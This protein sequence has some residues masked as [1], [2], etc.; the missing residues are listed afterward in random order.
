MNKRGFFRSVVFSAAVL[1]VILSSFLVNATYAKPEISYVGQYE[2]SESTSGSGQTYRTKDAGKNTLLAHDGT[3]NLSNATVLKSGNPKDEAKAETYGTNAAVLTLGSSKI[4]LRK[5]DVTTAAKY[6][7]GLFAREDSM[8][9]LFETSLKTTMKDSSA[10]VVSGG[11]TISV[12]EN[13]IVI[14]E[15][16]GS[17]LA[18]FIDGGGEISVDRSFIDADKES[19]FIVNNSKA[20]ITL[21]ATTISFGKDSSAVEK[22]DKKR[23]LIDAS[24]AKASVQILTKRS[25]LFGNIVA[26][27]K[28]VLNIKFTERTSYRGT[29]NAKKAAKK[30][31]LVLDSSSRV[32]LT[33]D[34]YVADLRNDK[35]DNSNIFANGHKLYV[36]GEEVKINEAEPEEWSYDMTTESTIPAEPE[37][38]EE[39]KD[40]T[41]LYILLGASVFL[42][43]VALFSVR[44]IIRKNTRMKQRYMEQKTVE[45]VKNNNMKK[46]W[47]KRA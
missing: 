43:F 14:T 37:V 46:P 25:P 32:I 5:S 30:V 7:Y 47:E 38:P 36:A 8:V 11:G 19:I 23:N 12:E 16:K 6:G 22:G 9:E 4:R 26:S 3:V 21:D 27:G 28:A 33:G 1:T 2:Y 40:K 15:E 31:V 18:K 39:K 44:M 35:K 17:S 13:S 10:L 41:F 45:K 24:G 34:S 29:I 20:K 42:F